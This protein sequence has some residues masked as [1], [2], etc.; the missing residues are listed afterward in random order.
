MFD[1]LDL[2]SQPVWLVAIVVVLWLLPKVVKEFATF[3]PPLAERLEALQER[4]NAILHHKLNSEAANQAQ[5]VKIQDRLLSIL[6][7]SLRKT[8]EDRELTGERLTEIGS[9]IDSLRSALNHNTE[10][11]RTHTATVSKLSD[12][13]ESFG[14]VG[15]QIASVGAYLTGSG[16]G[17]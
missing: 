13:V 17:E 7:E 2:N 14:R 3:I 11:L 9:E 15:A 16:G 10:V 12:E 6:E 1:K 5:Q 4:Q 8:W